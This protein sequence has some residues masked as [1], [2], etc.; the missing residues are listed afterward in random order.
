M[1]FI[2]SRAGQSILTKEWMLQTFGYSV[3]SAINGFIPTITSGKNSFVLKVEHRTS[4]TLLP[5]Y[6]ADGPRYKALG[7]SMA[8]PVMAWIGERIALHMPAA[9]DNAP[10]KEAA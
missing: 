7:N 2:T 4:Y 1:R 6:D 9:N 3:L 8:V 5:G 10:A